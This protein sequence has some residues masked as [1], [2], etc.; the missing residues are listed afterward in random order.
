[1]AATKK[2]SLRTK[3]WLWIALASLIIGGLLVLLLVR[4]I[5]TQSGTQKTATEVSQVFV[6]SL[7]KNAPKT[8]YKYTSAEF[9]A[10]TKLEQL[11][12]IFNALSHEYQGTAKVTARKLQTNASGTEQA[13]VIYTIDTSAGKRF[14]RIVLEKHHGWH[15]TNFRTSETAL[16]TSSVY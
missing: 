10:G 5:R 8:T 1:M 11:T 15:I 3:K 4:A 6:D 13:I 16:D 9:R 2:A 7:Q 12:Q 14:V